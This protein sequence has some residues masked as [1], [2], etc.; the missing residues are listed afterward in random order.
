MQEPVDTRDRFEDEPPFSRLT[1]FTFLWACQ[2]LAH[3][4]FWQA[5]I[6][7]GIWTGWMLTGL[8]FA[9]LIRPRSI[10]LFAAL[11]ATSVLYNFIRL[12]YVANH[13]HVEALFNITMLCAL[14]WTLVTRRREGRTVVRGA[15]DELG[16]GGDAERE[17]LYQRFAP[18][19]MVSMVVM[20]GFAVVAKLNVD[21]LDPD[22]SCTTAMFDDFV[23]R[24]PFLPNERWFHTATIYQVV[25][26]EA[27]IPILFSF[28]NTRLWAIAIGL[29]F[30]LI[31][32]LLGHRT[33]SALVFVLYFLFVSE[34]FIESLNRVRHWLD[35]R[36]GAGSA[37]RW[38]RGAVVAGVAIGVLLIGA[39]LMG[40]TREG[41]GPARLYR[42]PW[43]AWLGFS[44]VMIF[45]YFSILYRQRMQADFAP[46]LPRLA[47]ARPVLLWIVVV[48]VFFNGLTQYIGLKTKSSFTMY[49][50]LT[51]EADRWNHYFMPSA[52]RIAHFQD[53]LV[54]IVS[55]N[56]PILQGHVDRS[57]LITF[58]EL[59]RITS[60]AEDDLEL[61]YI[62]AGERGRIDLVKGVLDDPRLREPAPLLA[63]KFLSFRPVSMG[64]RQIC[65]H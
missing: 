56:H 7:E 45:L 57:E 50:N 31:L 19:L 24:F 21:F 36:F 34:E 1:V 18:I 23:R 13:I 51:T 26:I 42:L 16:F 48:L 9:V 35:R 43:L 39:E 25:A 6:W 2:A 54:E 14:G 40:W 55:T 38:L 61:E 41:V 44:G 29:P 4:E 8:A 17:Y 12:P 22:I 47:G 49:S 5:W 53:E 3:Q 63:E 10:V 46:A 15:W 27:A 28:K 62:Y 32:G 33:F 60:H 20:Y 30:H 37:S 64:E 59:R 11:L 65:F 58:F 52:L